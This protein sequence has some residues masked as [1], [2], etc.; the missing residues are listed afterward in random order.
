MKAY[1]VASHYMAHGVT[2]VL[3]ALAMMTIATDTEHAFLELRRA[4]MLSLM[5]RVCLCVFLYLVLCLLTPH[6]LRLQL[7]LFREC[8]VLWPAGRQ[9]VQ[10][11]SILRRHQ[12]LFAW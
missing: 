7:C 12:V 9:L 10:G 8:T 11:N 6:A 4:L 2:M 5:V 3:G 1:I